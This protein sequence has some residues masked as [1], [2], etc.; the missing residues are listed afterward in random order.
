MVFKVEEVAL[1]KPVE[2]G[3]GTN[4]EAIEVAGDERIKQIMILMRE[5]AYFIW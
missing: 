5:V 2:T 3:L 4:Q 1:S